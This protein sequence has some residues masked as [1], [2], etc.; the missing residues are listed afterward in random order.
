MVRHGTD[1]AGPFLK[2]I[3]DENRLFTRSLENNFPTDW[4]FFL[5]TNLKNAGL[6]SEDTYFSD[7]TVIGTETQL[8]SSTIHILATLR[9]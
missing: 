8:I 2:A 9:L 7:I 4:S 3:V 5:M 1:G 6:H